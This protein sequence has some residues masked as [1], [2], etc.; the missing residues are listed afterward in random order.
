MLL[1]R[2]GL[3]EWLSITG[4]AFVIAAMAGWLGWW[5]L[6]VIVIIVWLALLAFFR[7]PMRRLPAGL[8]EGELLSPADGTVSAV[9]RVAEHDAANGPAVIVRIFLSIFNV[10]INR[11]PCA[12]QVIDVYHKPGRYLDARRVESARVNESNLLTLQRADGTLIGVRQVSGAVA[13]RIVCDTI[14][15]A[16]LMR[17][18]KFGMIKFGSTTEL[19][20]PER[21]DIAIRVAEGD[22]VKA[23]LTV[24]IDLPFYQSDETSSSDLGESAATMR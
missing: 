6:V 10:H 5:W 24:L 1:T 9:E 12:A 13:R 18:E 2:Y 3:R 17:G 19:I 15:D 21:D 22:R 20:V 11:S 8:G 23:G 14:A 7:D 4:I 16:R